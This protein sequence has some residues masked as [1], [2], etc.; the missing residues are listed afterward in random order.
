MP[1]Q[2]L[3][4]RDGR[5]VEVNAPIGAS[6]AEL[7]DLANRQE[8]VRRAR[9]AAEESR[10]SLVEGRRGSFSRGLDIGTDLVAQLPLLVWGR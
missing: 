4:F 3:Q 6:K 5:T 8:R 7:V 10:L 1:L 2:V 9:E